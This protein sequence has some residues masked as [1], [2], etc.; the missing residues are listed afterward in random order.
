MSE[1]AYDMNGDP[2]VLPAHAQY[3]RVRRFRSPGSRGAPEVVTTREGGPL[4][5]PIDV[6]FLEFKEIVE[7][8]PGRYRLDPIDEKRRIIS[9]APA[10]YLTIAEPPPRNGAGLSELG[11]L[12]E[13]DCALRELARANVEMARVNADVSRNIA[14]R[15][16]GIMQAAAEVIRA[17]DGAGIVARQPLEL[18][19]EPD[20]GEN[21]EEEA[22]ERQEP[23]F[24]SLAAQILPM[25]QMWLQVKQAKASATAPPP[26]AETPASPPP[27]RNAM[28]TP[29]QMAHILEVQKQLTPQEA[30]VAR[31]TAAKLSPEDQAELLAE[32]ETMTVE[33]AAA[34]VRSMLPKMKEPAS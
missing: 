21:D 17:A 11:P 34:F 4:I 6:G 28:P 9:N 19:V 13:G 18:A 31:A 12:S 29:A 23:T 25:I 20:Q 32:L 33:Q 3:W 30:A 14:D 22:E 10:A 7:S 27:P 2:I 24:A 8:V 1:L 5:L 15:F 26:G 16:A